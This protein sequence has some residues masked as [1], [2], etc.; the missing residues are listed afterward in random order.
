MSENTEAPAPSSNSFWTVVE[1]TEA[2]D[3]WSV[4]EMATIDGVVVLRTTWQH[5]IGGQRVSGTAVVKL[6]TLVATANGTSEAPMPMQIH[7]AA[8]LGS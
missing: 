5:R 6:S 1:R 2:D 4:S 8:D 3:A 7:P